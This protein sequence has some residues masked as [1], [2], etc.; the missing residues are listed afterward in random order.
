MLN[1]DTH[2]V[3]HL[4]AGDLTPR[5]LGIVERADLAICD[6]S[7]WE[8]A[9]L[10]DLG[11]LSIELNGPEFRRFLSIAVLIPLTLE[12]ALQSTRLDYSADPADEIIG[13]TSLVYQI[14]LLTRDRRIRKS[15]LVPL[16]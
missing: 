3:V 7:L 1:L 16:A 11:R 13:A 2:M 6:I 4:L 5:E 12:I 15:K 9:K 14:P 10:V 8:L